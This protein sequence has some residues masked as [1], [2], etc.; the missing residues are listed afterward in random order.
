M[1]EDALA[2]EAGDTAQ[3]DTGRDQPCQVGAQARGEQPAGGG[4]RWRGGMRSWRGLRVVRGG[5]D[6]EA[7][8]CAVVALEYSGAPPRLTGRGRSRFKMIPP[9][10]LA[11]TVWQACLSS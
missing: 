11:C 8:S 10:A 6:G 1:R 4:I 2:D 7:R 9:R 5:Y 3:Q